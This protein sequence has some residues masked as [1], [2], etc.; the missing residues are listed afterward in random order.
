MPNYDFTGNYGAGDLAPSTSVDM[1]AI[2]GVANA[3]VASFHSYQMDKVRFEMEADRANFK[4]AAL[5]ESRRQQG[6]F[7]GH[8]REKLEESLASEKL[9]MDIEHMKDTA[10]VKNAAVAANISNASSV[11]R[12]VERSHLRAE[13]YQERQ[14]INQLEK[15]K[16]QAIEAQR[17]QEVIYDPQKP[18]AVGAAAQFGVKALKIGQAA[19]SPFVP[20]E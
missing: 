3:A 12:D 4:R 9:A 11:V 16:V 10:R 20:A 13:L 5:A 6:F 19:Y 2:A 15:L 18:N 14:H 8:N 7:Y 17:S 1:E